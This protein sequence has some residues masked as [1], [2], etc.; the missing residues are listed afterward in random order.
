MRRHSI[1]L[2]VTLPLLFCPPAFSQPPG[3][4][5]GGRPGAATGA[6]LPGMPP[7]SAAR[8]TGT[9]RIRGRVVAADTGA[10]LRRAQVQA[11]AADAQARRTTTTDADG[12]YEFTDLPAGRFVV[13]VSKTGYVTLQYGQRRAFQAGTPITVAEGQQ[14]DRIDVSLPRGAVIA[15]RVTDDFGDPLAGVQVQVQRYQYGP[16]GQRRLTPVS[17]GIFLGLTTTDDRGET[18]LF[19]LMPGEYVVSAIARSGIVPTLPNSTDTSEG[20]APTFYPGTVN[21][22]EAQAV[23][24]TAGNE[25]A[26]QFSMVPAR[27]ARISGT[28]VDSEGRPFAGAMVQLMSRQGSGI[29][30]FGAGSVSTDGTFTI[31]GVPPG[32]HSI[33]VRPIPRPGATG[34][35]FASVPIV[36][37]GSD[38]TGIRV[39]TSR[40]ALVTGRVV[41]EGTSPRV[42]PGGTPLRVFA[43]PADVSRPL[44]MLGGGDPLTNGTLDESGVFQYAGAFGRLFFSVSTPPPWTLKSV[45]LDGEDITDEPI[46][47]TGKQSVSNLVITL[48]DRVTQIAGQVS[49]AQGRTLR[50]YVVVLLPA[51]AIQEPV[52]LGRVIRTARPDSNGR[53]QARVRPGR[54]VAAAVEDLEQGR[55]FAPEFQEQLRRGA[56][57]IAVREGDTV[58]VDLKLTTGL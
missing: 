33:E 38:L 29:T 12:R 53:F 54:Y 24:V 28:I 1:L 9:A 27:L 4:A 58:T 13:S 19:G 51:E 55:Q 11:V 40:G 47:F 31:S 57:E 37:S 52:A 3:G 46:D 41:F 39:V 8:Q 26:I 36:V 17:T 5:A 45:T 44:L 18:R 56:R 30:T 23:S 20:F 25:T 48:T 42:L 7:P 35:E 32:E 2:A 14:L 21:S 50:D 6:A 34:A 10:P 49:D 16:D 15:V 22:A 43:Q